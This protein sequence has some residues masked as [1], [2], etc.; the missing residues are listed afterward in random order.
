M[1]TCGGHLAQVIVTGKEVGALFGAVMLLNMILCATL[2]AVFRAVTVR[3]LRKDPEVRRQ[4][5]YEFLPGWDIVNLAVA[6]SW[7]RRLVSCRSSPSLE[8]LRR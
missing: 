1:S 8:A 4:M 7:P 2:F 6:L 5:G 3:R